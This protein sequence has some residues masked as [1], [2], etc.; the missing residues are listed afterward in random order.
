MSPASPV[1]VGDE[2]AIPSKLPEH[3]A[4]E[5]LATSFRAKLNQLRAEQAFSIGEAQRAAHLKE[6]EAEYQATLSAI[7]KAVNKLCDSM[8]TDSLW[9][10]VVEKLRGEGFAVT[11]DE[12]C[13]EDCEDPYW[14]IAW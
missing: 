10:E 13:D 14:K 2:P 6:I 8:T 9:P 1:W 5:P 11:H 12:G 7:E 4:K 3:A